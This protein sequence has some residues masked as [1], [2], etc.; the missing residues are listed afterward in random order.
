[1]EIPEVLKMMG[2]RTVIEETDEDA[3]FVRARIF[4]PET[5]RECVPALG[6]GD[7]CPYKRRGRRP[8]C[9]NSAF[10]REVM[11]EIEDF[12]SVLFEKLIAKEADK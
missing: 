9:L 5:L 12:L 6:L 7:V 4:V 10:Q 2:Y 3:R 8:N 11:T 1:M